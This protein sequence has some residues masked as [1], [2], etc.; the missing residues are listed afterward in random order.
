MPDQ[1]RIVVATRNAGKR[2]ELAHHLGGL[3]LHLVDL[4]DYPDAP[5]VVE[6]ADSYRE[7]ALAKARAAMSHTGLPALADDSGLEVDALD[8]APG[9]RSARFARGHGRGGG[10]AANT[11]LLLQRLAGKVAS[12][13]AA[14]FRCVIAV[15]A[16]SGAELVV[17][18]VCEGRI[19]DR[20]AGANGFGYDPVFYHSGAG[21]TFASIADEEKRRLSHRAAACLK[22]RRQLG[23]FLA[24][25]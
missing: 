17:D 16:T 3:D 7:N 24:R 9:V 12:E 2:I 13:R 25:G 1:R 20:P 18:G 5:E 15:V 4:S 22:L 11:A 6:D 21:A 10:D 14:R 23:E 19:A 8:G